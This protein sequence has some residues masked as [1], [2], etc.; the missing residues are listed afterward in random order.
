[1]EMQQSIVLTINMF[2]RIGAIDKSVI[3]VI[4]NVVQLSI[5]FFTLI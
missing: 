5:G 2:V 1:M 4:S 3:G